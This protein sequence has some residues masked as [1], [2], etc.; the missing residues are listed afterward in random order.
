MQDFLYY[1]L[2]NF[3][4][5]LSWCGL[6]YARI[7]DKEWVDVRFTFRLL[8][9]GNLIGIFFF[10]RATIDYN[11]VMDVAT[12]AIYMIAFEIFFHFKIKNMPKDL[13]E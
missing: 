1:L 11:V 2:L 12:F 4:T 6:F 9:I 8:A 10:A 3:I 5:T 13:V 7:R